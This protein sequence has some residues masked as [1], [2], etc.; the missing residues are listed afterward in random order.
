MKYDTMYKSENGSALFTKDGKLSTIVYDNGLILKQHYHN[1]G[2][3]A[4]TELYYGGNKVCV[5]IYDEN[6]SPIS[7]IRSIR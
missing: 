1:N 7:E 3:V 5:F 4:S 6:G 2:S